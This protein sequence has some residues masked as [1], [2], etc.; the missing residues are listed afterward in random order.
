M[1]FGRKILTIAFILLPVML[2]AVYS[3]LQTREQLIKHVYEERRTMASLSARVLDEK[4]D[5]L[6]HIGLS[7]ATRPVFRQYTDEGKWDAAIDLMKDVPADFPYIAR[8]FITDT[9]GTVMADA[10]SIT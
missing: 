5:H 8:V 9:T 4:L 2:V 1:T 6:N 3:F 7:L 10:P